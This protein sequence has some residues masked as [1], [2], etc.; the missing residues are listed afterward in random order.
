[1]TSQG[2]FLPKTPAIRVNA[3]TDQRLVPK[4]PIR[5]QQQFSRCHPQSQNNHRPSTKP[6]TDYPYIL[7]YGQPSIDDASVQKR[8]SVTGWRVDPGAF[9]VKRHELNL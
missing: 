7:T 4:Y 8:R 5:G 9:I 1:M 6:P 2:H 3:E